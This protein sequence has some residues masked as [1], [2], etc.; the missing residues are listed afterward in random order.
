ME[1]QPLNP[2]D[3]LFRFAF[4]DL[5]VARDF[6]AHYLPAE[7]SRELDVDTLTSVEGTFIDEVLEK[8]VSDALF[9]V[10]MR[11]RASEEQNDEAL[12]Y[13]LVEHKSYPDRM[14]ARQVL[15]YVDRIWTQEERNNP[16]R[17]SL[18]PVLPV[19]FYHGVSE[20]NVAMDLTDLIDA[21]LAFRAYMPQMRYLLWDLNR[22]DT[23]QLVGSVQI[24]L[25]LRLLEV[26]RADD[27]L[28][29][30]SEVTELL[31]ELAEPKTVL[32]W[33]TV[34]LHYL[35]ANPRVGREEATEI[36]RRLVPAGEEGEK[37]MTA[38]AEVWFNDGLEQ[39]RKEGKEEGR[40]EGLRQAI[41]EI[42]VAQYG[43]LPDALTAQ[44]AGYD[45]VRL[46]QVLAVVLDAENLEALTV[47][48][49][50]TDS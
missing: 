41:S 9:R 30:T 42:I 36:A 34:G 6:V 45:L 27:F 40:E 44:L 7:I 26:F 13:V 10:K 46:K 28:A 49:R 17:S 4:A 37:L 15:R 24:R 38:L 12:I 35:S 23:N 20:W 39:G 22:T 33:V 18:I 31:G 3:H 50:F 25:L 19:V 1:R 8:H 32:E 21:P 5:A 48:L 16:Q 2:H 47:Q 11:N 14:T 43:E 29:R